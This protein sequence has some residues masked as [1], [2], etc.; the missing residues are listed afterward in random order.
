MGECKVSSD[1]CQANR[2]EFG[3][4]CYETDEEYVLS[5]LRGNQ[6]CLDYVKCWLLA[7]EL[8]GVHLPLGY[9]IYYDTQSYIMSKFLCKFTRKMR[10]EAGRLGT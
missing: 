2:L 8:R 4:L 10:E 7:F 6:D 3:G 9:P 1:N 5:Q